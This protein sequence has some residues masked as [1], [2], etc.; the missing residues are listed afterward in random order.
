MAD[1]PEIGTC[2]GK[3]IAKLLGLAPKGNDS[4]QRKGRRITGGGRGAVRSIV[5]LV[6]RG[7]ARFHDGLKAFHQRL[8]N[9]GKPLMVIPIALA[10]KLLVILNAKARDARKQYAHAT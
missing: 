1:L 8:S 3:A 2:N 10:R 6:A 4:G 7:A 5:F 9:A